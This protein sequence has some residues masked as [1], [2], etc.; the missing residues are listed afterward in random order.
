[1]PIVAERQAFARLVF[2]LKKIAC[3]IN[4]AVTQIDQVGLAMGN[5][6]VSA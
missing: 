3:N 2:F 4:G 1:L 5:S 6:P